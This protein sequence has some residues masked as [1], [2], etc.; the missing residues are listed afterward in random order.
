VSDGRAE[1]EL[2]L[3][4]DR[5]TFPDGPSANR[6][7]CSRTYIR[8]AEGQVRALAVSNKLGDGEPFMRRNF[9]KR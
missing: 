2:M 5:F 3:G 8:T 7:W 4:Y 1:G 6:R 9:L